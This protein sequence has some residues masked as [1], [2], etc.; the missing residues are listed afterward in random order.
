MV[1]EMATEVGLAL[2]PSKSE[3]SVLGAASEQERLA[4]LE[5]FCAVAP[6]IVDIL[7]ADTTLRLSPLTM[8]AMEQV[9]QKKTRKLEASTARLSQLTAHSA[10]FL[11]HASRVSS[12]SSGVLLPSERGTYWWTMTRF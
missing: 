1:K 7:P 2:N 9:L 12:I 8:P 5:S 4:V 3:V 6:G 11:L 10:F